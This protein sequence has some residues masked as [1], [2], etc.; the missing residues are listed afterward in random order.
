[1]TQIILNSNLN[2]TNITQTF[3]KEGLN[4]IIIFPFINF[5]NNNLFSDKIYLILISLI[6]QKPSLDI[7]INDQK[8]INYQDQIFIQEFN[9]T[10]FNINVIEKLSN[11]KFNFKLNISNSLNLIDNTVFDQTFFKA[12][13]EKFLKK[14]ILQKDPR[15]ITQLN[16]TI[17]KT[18]KHDDE[19][20][21]FFDI[22]YYT[23]SYLNKNSFCIQYF[24][25]KELSD[26]NIKTRPLCIYK[27]KSIYRKKSDYKIVYDNRL[28]VSPKEHYLITEKIINYIKF[29]KN[30]YNYLGQNIFYNKESFFRYK[31][32]LLN[33]FDKIRNFQILVDINSETLRNL[34]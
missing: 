34:F 14:I 32:L 17:D 6:D 27:D 2:L 20:F 23:N 22:F 15:Y 1:M 26:F 5:K 25:I 16:I 33:P 7:L 9:L 11:Q 13:N 8:I 3:K 21:N 18:F 30:N 12:L 28:L 29:L 10:D 19:I 31:F 4:D 24:N